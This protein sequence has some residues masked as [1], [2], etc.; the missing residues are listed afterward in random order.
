MALDDVFN[1]GTP[2]VVEGIAGFFL[3]RKPSLAPF[4]YCY[5]KLF[6]TTPEFHARYLR[7][8]LKFLDEAAWLPTCERTQ[9]SRRDNRQANFTPAI[10]GYEVVS[11]L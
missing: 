5:N 4:A 10:F 2:G 6:V 1:P 7:E 8:T 11:F 3:R 9:R